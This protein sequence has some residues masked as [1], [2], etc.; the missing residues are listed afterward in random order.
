[1]AD[2][3]LEFEVV[4]IGAGP[5][6]LAAACAAAESGRRIAVLDETPWL[7]GQIW[8][9][10]QTHPSSPV[11]K[12][13]FERLK[14]SGARVMSG[15]TVIGFPAEHLLLAECNTGPLQVKWERLILATGARELFLP[16]PGWTLPGVVGPGGLQTLIKNGWPVSGRRAVVAGS[17]PL[18]LVIANTLRKGGAHVARIVE[19]AAQKRVFR[20]AFRLSARPAK[21]WQAAN[22]RLRLLGTP[23]DFGE[24]PIR[25]QGTDVVHSVTL[26]DG[27]KTRTEECDLLACGFGL[28]P[29]VEL[30]L[31]LGCKL[32][33][34]FVQVDDHQTTTAPEVF[35]A[36]EPTGIGGAD[37]ALVEG[38]IAGYAAAGQKAKAEALLPRRASWHRFR[39]ALAEAFAVRPELKT[40]ATEDTLLCRCED[41]ALGRVRRFGSWREAKLQSRC[42]MGAC[43]GRICGAASKFLLGWGMESVRPPLL[44]ARVESLIAGDSTT[45]GH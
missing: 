13:W 36:G 3:V 5:A 45:N 42:G 41:V 27:N 7:G 9:G 33:G 1:M 16:F 28:V 18:L 2:P 26:T 4:I 31:A 34:D 39:T 6:G 22:L 37:C 14:R 12:S 23:Y 8:R 21:L 11:A 44:P 19:Q 40:V 43:Q 15:V 10:Q 35:C 29:N 17:G 30:A 20:F 24:W 38:Q 25:A 32:N